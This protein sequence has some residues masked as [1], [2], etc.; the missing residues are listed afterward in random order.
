[1]RWWQDFIKDDL[2]LR[3]TKRK[4]P[5]LRTKTRGQKGKLKLISGDSRGNWCVPKLPNED[6]R[7]GSWRGEG[8]GFLRYKIVRLGSCRN[9][10]KLK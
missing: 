1:M 4:K 9:G 3:G 2:N 6:K 5:T 8:G 7:G 10:M